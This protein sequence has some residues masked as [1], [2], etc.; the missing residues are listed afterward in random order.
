MIIEVMGGN[1]LHEEGA[2]PVQADLVSITPAW[3]IGQRYDAV[4]DILV[5]KRAN[6]L[7]SITRMRVSSLGLP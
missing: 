4:L 6:F 7:S 2:Q 1:E 3:V 5:D